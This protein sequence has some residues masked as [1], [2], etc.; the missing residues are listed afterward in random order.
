MYDVSHLTHITIVNLRVGVAGIGH[1][2]APEFDDI[3]LMTWY[4]WRVYE[5]VSL[6]D[7]DNIVNITQQLTY[8]RI[9]HRY[10]P[11]EIDMRQRDGLWYFGEMGQSITL[12]PASM[13]ETIW[14]LDSE[15]QKSQYVLVSD[16]SNWYLSDYFREIA[17][18]GGSSVIVMEQSQQS[19]VDY[20]DVIQTLYPKHRIIARTVG[21]DI[22]QWDVI[23]DEY[24]DEWYGCDAIWLG[25]KL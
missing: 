2:L 11:S 19:A 4:G 10:L 6:S 13:V 12:F 20:I 17:A 7:L 24:R 9:T 16:W 8:M 22:R 23:V 18:H 14:L 1:K 15:E 25:R 3:A 21:T 5:P